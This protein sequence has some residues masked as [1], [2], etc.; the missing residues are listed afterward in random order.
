MRFACF[1]N[2]NGPISLLCFDLFSILVPTK[3][4]SGVLKRVAAIFIEHEKEPLPVQGVNQQGRK[5]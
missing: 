1:W 5:E 4:G 3:N 2:L